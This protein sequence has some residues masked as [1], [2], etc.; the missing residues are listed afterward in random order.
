MVAFILP[1][2]LALNV[3]KDYDY[4][5]SIAVYFGRLKDKRSEITSLRVLLT[6]AVFAIAFAVLGNLLDYQTT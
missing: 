4:E 5:G 1:L 2:A 6:V 3:A